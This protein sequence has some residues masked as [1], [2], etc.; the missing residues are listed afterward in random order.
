MNLM[1]PNTYMG[2]SNNQNDHLENLNELGTNLRTLYMGGSNSQSD[3]LVDLNEFGSNPGTL[4]AKIYKPEDLPT[5]APLVV[6]LHGSDQTAA[7]YDVGAG[8]SDIAD[9]YGV[10]LLFPEQQ[11]VNNLTLSFNWFEPD[12]CHR[13]AGEPLS[14]LHMVE[15]VVSDHGIDRQRI[16]IT[17]LSAGGAMTSVMLATYPEIFAG[18]A[19]IAGLPYGGADTLPEALLRMKGLGYPTAQ[20]LETRLRNASTH[21]GPWPILSVWHGSGD[22]TVNASNANAILGQ[23]RGIHD[24]EKRPSST[25][26]VNGYP[27]RVWSNAEG[28]ELIEEYSIT[29][30][31]HG[32]PLKTYGKNSYGSRG[33]YMLEVNISST[34]HIADFWG[35]SA[36]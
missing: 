18:G 21:E 36:T 4:N 2:G 6:V 23:W 11:R 31:G 26:I 27:R 9:L 32:T 24:L 7:D 19:I 8:W 13:G 10:A 20:Q 29:G 34:R 17:G 25:N 28:R 33:D 1:D 30:M 14:I 5:G 15:Q 12:D 35:L 16:F 3:R 22:R